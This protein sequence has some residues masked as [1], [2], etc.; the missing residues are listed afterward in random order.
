MNDT[1]YHTIEAAKRRA[2]T[3]RRRANGKAPKRLVTKDATLTEG[4]TFGPVRIDAIKGNRISFCEDRKI[5][6]TMLAEAFVERFRK[7]IPARTRG[8]KE[9]SK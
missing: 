2:D 3:A 8:T 7:H 1:D 4:D 6:S 9:A 5:P